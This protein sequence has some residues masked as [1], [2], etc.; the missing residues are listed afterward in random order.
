ME[1]DA[2]T[3]KH[4]DLCISIALGTYCSYAAICVRDIVQMLPIDDGLP[5]F[6]TYLTFYEGGR[7]LGIP[8]HGLSIRNPAN[9]VY[10]FKKLLGRSFTDPVLQS[11]SKSWFFRIQADSNNDP[12]VVLQENGQP[13]KLRPEYL[14]SM[15]FSRIKSSA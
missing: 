13:I 14:T 8:A 10:E 7:L 3:N 5:D 15:I 2:L 1:D 9:T 4:S 12:L 11:D 6:V